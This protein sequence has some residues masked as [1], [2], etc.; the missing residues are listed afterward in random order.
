MENDRISKRVFVG[1][2]AG[3]R[4]VGRLR[5]RWIDTVKDYFEEKSFG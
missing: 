2:Y 5:K 3:N 1:E 4:S